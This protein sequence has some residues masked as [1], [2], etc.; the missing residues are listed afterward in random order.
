MSAT[1]IRSGR[2][3]AVLTGATLLGVTALVT[4]ATFTDNAWLSLNGGAGWGGS[5][6]TFA[7][8]A[9]AGNETTLDEV[10]AWGDYSNPASAGIVVMDEDSIV[11]NPDTPTST[12][13]VNMPVRN[14]TAQLGADV[15]LGLVATTEA[16]TPAQQAKNEAYLAA[17]EFEVAVDGE[18]KE[19]L[20]YDEITATS[21]FS[22]GILEAAGS[23]TGAEGAEQTPTDAA[24]VTLT[25]RLVTPV[26][27]TP[28]AYN[29]GGVELLAHFMGSS[30][31]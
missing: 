14:I 4:A 13:V 23:T 5:D 15:D 3:R 22:V 17:M 16:D 29:G 25:V 18:F 21:P 19:R 27:S 2:K 11:L 12:A 20:R 8:Q 1:T 10:T 7:I 31:A 26:G 6:Q 30:V 28:D 24:I 9:S